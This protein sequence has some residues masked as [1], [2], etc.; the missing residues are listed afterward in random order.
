M[1]A[2]YLKQ[3]GKT[4]E[5]D[6]YFVVNTFEQKNIKYKHMYFLT[7]SISIL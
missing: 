1:C 4:T 7:A 5:K 2:R 6:G 3:S